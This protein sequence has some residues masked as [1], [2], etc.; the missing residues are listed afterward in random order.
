[1]QAYQAIDELNR[2]SMAR[3]RA[4]SCRR[5]T[6]A[7]LKWLA[8]HAAPRGILVNGVAPASV[9]T[10]MMA[11]Q[12]VDLERIP[13]GRKA[14]VEEVAWAHRIPLLPGGELYL[15]GSHRRE[16]RRLHGVSRWGNLGG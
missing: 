15:R 1:M 16:R 8:R 3:C 5:R 13:L 4:D 12:P 2:A 11:D 10:S 7:L 6:Y 14:Q 9:D